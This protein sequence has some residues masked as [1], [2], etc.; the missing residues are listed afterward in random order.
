MGNVYQT[1][2]YLD[3]ALALAVLDLGYIGVYMGKRMLV[4]Y[5]PHGEEISM[6]VLLLYFESIA[7]MLKF[8]VYLYMNFMQSHEPHRLASTISSR[9]SILA[10]LQICPFQRPL[11]ILFIGL[12]STNFR[13]K[14]LQP[15]GAKASVI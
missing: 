15:S 6:F 13:L 4:G 14:T 9:V 1:I 5:G 11:S 12:W 2:K 7:F 8:S 10:L 3:N